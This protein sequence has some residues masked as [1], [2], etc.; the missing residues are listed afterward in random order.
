[1]HMYTED[2]IKH[3]INDISKEY[4]EKWKQEI[5][6]KTH[7]VD[8]TFWYGGEGCEGK[9]KEMAEEEKDINSRIMKEPVMT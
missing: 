3:N 1:M 8:F 7:R 5:Y 4:I 2:G 9:K 6:Q